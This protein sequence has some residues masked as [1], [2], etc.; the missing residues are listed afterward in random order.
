[1]KTENLQPHALI[2]LNYNPGAEK[3]A[4]AG[5]EIAR[6]MGARITLLH[7]LSEPSFYSSAE[8]SPIMGFTGYSDMSTWVQENNEQLIAESERF[9][10]HIKNHLEDPAIQILIREGNFADTILETAREKNAT[11]ILLGLHQHH[12]LGIQLS[13]NVTEKVMHSSKVPIVLIPTQ[14]SETELNSDE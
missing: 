11:L 8:Y 3:I 6:N 12:G 1:M 10:T 13:E 2:A 5:Y 4:E 7:V 9:L 14:E